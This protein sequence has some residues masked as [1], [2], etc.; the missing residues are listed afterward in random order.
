MD[1]QSKPRR[2]LDQHNQKIQTLQTHQMNP[3]ISTGKKK[4]LKL[5]KRGKKGKE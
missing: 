5:P 1:S 4:Q 3:S 2:E